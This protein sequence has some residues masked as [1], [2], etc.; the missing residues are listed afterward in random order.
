MEILNDGRLLVCDFG[1]FGATGQIYTVDRITGEIRIL[2][3]GGMLRDPVSAH[4][5]SDG[6]LW[7]A[8]SYMHYYYPVRG[9]LLEKDDGEILCITPDGKQTVLVPRQSPA[10]G[11]MVGIHASDNSDEI[12]AIKGDW[13]LMETGAVLRV[14]KHTGRVETLL[15]AAP[16]DPK[17]YSTHVAI[18]GHILWVGEGY[19]KQVIGYD[20]QRNA[21]VKVLDFSTVMGRYKGVASSF[22]GIESV[23]VV[24]Q[25][26]GS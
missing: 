26:I 13:P 22:E 8:N 7:V 24:P 6:T 9:G 23:S 21:V 4:Y 11:S 10:N 5:D 12:I 1:G 18:S 20:L 15:S 14:N 25:N 2:A 17:F 3:E 19:Y 16:G